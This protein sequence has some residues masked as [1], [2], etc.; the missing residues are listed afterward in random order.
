MRL[1][2]HL[3]EAQ[4]LLCYKITSLLTKIPVSGCVL[5]EIVQTTSTGTREKTGDQEERQ[6]VRKESVNDALKKVI[7]LAK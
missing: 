1:R 7:L 3:F 2:A 5:Q 6:G 4:Q